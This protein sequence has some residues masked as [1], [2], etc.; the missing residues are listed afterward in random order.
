MTH[1]GEIK[2]NRSEQINELAAALAAAQGEMTGALKDSANPFF[3][4]KYADLASCWDACRTPLAKNGLSVVQLTE[5]GEPVTVEWETTN[6]KT[7]EVSAFKVATY[8][9]VIVTLLMHS[10]GQYISSALALIPREMTEMGM[11]ACLTYGR[12]YGFTAMIGIAQVDQ[13]ESGDVKGGKAAYDAPHKPQ[14]A[15]GADVPEQVAF[16]TAVGMRELLEADLEERLK[17]LKVL[18]RHDILNRNQDLYSAASQVL[19][20]AE[21]TSWKAF[22]SMAKAAEK[23][24]RATA[25]TNG[26]RF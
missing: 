2:M 10:S 20:A 4:S 6:Q 25:P 22:V 12:R 19:K 7:G 3:K 18:D 5:K 23:E 16:E 13:I 17:A 11:G 8:E 26:R 1:E 21:R 15:L 9:L 14:G 24:D